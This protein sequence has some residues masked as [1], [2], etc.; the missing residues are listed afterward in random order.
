[1]GLRAVHRY[2]AR[3]RDTEWT[4]RERSR[5]MMCEPV[6]AR[7]IHEYLL[8]RPILSRPAWLFSFGLLADCKYASVGL[9]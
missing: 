8:R 1:M 4:R 2:V 9:T 3:I 7:V 5:A 6:L